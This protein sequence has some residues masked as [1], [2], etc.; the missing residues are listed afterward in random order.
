MEPS[1]D[2]TPSALRRTL[3]EAAENRMREEAWVQKQ[4]DKAAGVGA[5][6]GGTRSSSTSLEV[7]QQYIVIEDVNPPSKKRRF[8]LPSKELEKILE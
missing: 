1:R 3:L 5:S 8:V 2:S 6:T 4:K 7:D